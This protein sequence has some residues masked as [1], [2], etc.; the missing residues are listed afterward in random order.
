MSELEKHKL[1]GEIR[2]IDLEKL[3]R[4][5]WNPNVMSAKEFDR[6]T[7]ELAESGVRDPIQVIPLGDDNYRILGGH[8]RVEAAKVLG[9]PTFPCLIIDD[10][11]LI[12]D[13]DLQKFVNMRLNVIKGKISPE[14]FLKLYNDLSKKFE[15]DA[16]QALMGLTDQDAFKLLLGDLKKDI[17]KS[18]LP[19]KI[20]EKFKE[21]A[22]ELKTID[23][24]S[25]ILNY[26]FNSYGN[27]LTHGY[28][29][30]VYGGQDH[31]YIS[32][33]DK[34]LKKKVHY[35]TET[36]SEKKIPIEP[37]FKRFLDKNEID[38][39]ALELIKMRQSEEEV[40]D[41]IEVSEVIEPSETSVDNNAAVGG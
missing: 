14:K 23:D 29:I 6:L 1:Q 11:N 39:I 31:V 3:L 10:V 18:D 17:D 24:I 4:S 41:P 28:M 25:N 7:E 35:L 33:E 37:F 30:L 22:N 8:H 38:N 2:D 27:T 36:C 19:D 26:L 21:T 20:K 13:E 12:Q 15:D 9:W 5:D 40:S 32:L 16:L 34:D